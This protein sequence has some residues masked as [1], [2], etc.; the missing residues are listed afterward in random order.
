MLD[1]AFGPLLAHVA[2]LGGAVRDIV[3]SLQRHFVKRVL[4]KM[5]LVRNNSGVV[6]VRAHLL[7]PGLKVGTLGVGHADGRLQRMVLAVY[8]RLP[9]LNINLLVTGAVGVMVV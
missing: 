2:V 7:L 8:G 5:I 4:A 9:V 1:Q 3:I 6:I